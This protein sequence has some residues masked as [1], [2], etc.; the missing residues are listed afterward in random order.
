[1]RRFERVFTDSMHPKS[2]ETPDGMRYAIIFRDEFWRYS[3]VH[4][5]SSKSDDPRA[6]QSYLADD[7]AEGGVEII[8]SDNGSEFAGSFPAMRQ[9]RD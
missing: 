1:M 7:R 4:F 5:L 6:L 2:V 3:W 9:T 8:G